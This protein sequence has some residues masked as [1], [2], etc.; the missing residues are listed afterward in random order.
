[1]KLA[2]LEN[3]LRQEEDG[4]IRVGASHVTLDVMLGF[5]VQGYTPEQLV[6]A[7][8]TLDLAD[9]YAAIAY[10]LRHRDEVDAYLRRREE[11]AD[12]LQR[13]IESQPGYK[14]WR[15]RLLAR[16]KQMGLR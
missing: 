2:P 1:M 9:V 8:P 13:E 10:Y 6:D 7:F 3:A 14:E 11:K 4:T 16:A 12:R 15:E 5:Y